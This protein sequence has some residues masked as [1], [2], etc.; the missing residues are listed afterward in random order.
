MKWIYVCLMNDII[1]ENY[2]SPDEVIIKAK[3]YKEFSE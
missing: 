1:L 2:L 3:Y